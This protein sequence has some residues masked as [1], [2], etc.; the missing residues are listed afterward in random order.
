[1]TFEQNHPMLL[2]IL[3]L[4]W[5]VLDSNLDSETHIP[6]TRANRQHTL[7]QINFAHVVASVENGNFERPFETHG[8]AL[9]RISLL[10]KNLL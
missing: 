4:K 9:M 1:M 10:Q 2:Q 5:Q 7:M 6:A 3:K 8:E